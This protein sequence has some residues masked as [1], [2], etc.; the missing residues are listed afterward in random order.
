MG[1]DRVFSF[2]F[3]IQDWVPFPMVL[4]APVVES[5]SDEAF[6]TTTPEEYYVKINATRHEIAKPWIFGI[7]ADEGYVGMLC[8][9]I[10]TVEGWSNN[11]IE[12]CV[13]LF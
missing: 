2:R 5:K 13:Y 6:L 9:F 11:I 8:K 3:S 10:E 7:T 12:V 1:N 4:F